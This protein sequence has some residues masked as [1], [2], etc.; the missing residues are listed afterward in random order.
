MQLI[1]LAANP[2]NLAGKVNLIAQNLSC[3]RVRPQG[4]QR[5]AHD[6]AGLLLVIEDG[7]DGAGHDDGEE[8][9]GAQ[10]AG[11]ACC[12]CWEGSVGA[13]FHQG[14]AAGS[15]GGDEGPAGRSM[16]SEQLLERLRS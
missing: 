13:A 10:P 14:T 3:R 7:E 1:D 9:E 12:D 16:L 8:R 15:W 5:A 2:R 11:N 4:V 6:G